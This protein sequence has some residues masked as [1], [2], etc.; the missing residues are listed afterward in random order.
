MSRNLSLKKVVPYLKSYSVTKSDQTIP[1]SFDKHFVHKE[2]PTSEQ[3]G[4]GFQEDC[5]E[6]FTESKKTE[7]DT[8][9]EVFQLIENPDF[10][11]L[12]ELSNGKKESIIRLLVRKLRDERGVSEYLPISYKN[13]LK[14]NKNEI[15]RHSIDW[16][17]NH[18]IS[19]V[20]F[21]M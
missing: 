17:Y 21:T 11:E 19:S 3:G 20:L 5:E 1:S 4:S 10:R 7:N 9:P 15:Y 12:F 8:L 18:R 6:N 14:L 16:Y 2:K 13:A